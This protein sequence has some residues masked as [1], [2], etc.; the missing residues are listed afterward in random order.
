MNAP[1]RHKTRKLTL[2]ERFWRHVSPEPNSGCWLWDGTVSGSGYGKL[3]FNYKQIAA[4]RYSYELHFGAIPSGFLICHRCD[5][6]CCVNPEHL[7]LGTYADNNRDAARKGRS[8]AAQG[9]KN[10]SA[11]LI[12]H[13]VADILRAVKSQNQKEIAK[14]FK[15]SPMTISNIVN[16]RSWKHVARG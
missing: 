13:D 9:S 16:G 6:R 15:V 10:G 5:V 3:R 2:E 7:F 12:E 11:K 8:Y 4:H 14:R 1:D